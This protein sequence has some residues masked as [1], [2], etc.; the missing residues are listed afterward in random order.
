MARWQRERY[1]E[2]GNTDQPPSRLNPKQESCL[3]LARMSGESRYGGR[4]SDAGTSFTVWVKHSA[5]LASFWPR[6]RNRCS[7]QGHHLRVGQI[8]GGYDCEHE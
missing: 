4:L 3:M 6:T 2:E 7:I 1:C 5:V 8:E